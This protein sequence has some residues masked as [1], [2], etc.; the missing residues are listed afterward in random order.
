[1]SD[2]QNNKHHALVP[3]L[4]GSLEKGESGAKRVLSAIISDTIAL[5]KREQRIRPRIVVVDDEDWML[6]LIEACI[7]SWSEHVTLL[8]FQNRNDAWQ[9]LLR[10]DPNLLI[11]DMN[12][13]NVPGRTQSFGMSGWHML[14]LLAERKVK[15]P[16]LVVSGSFSMS[17]VE[18][19]ARQC[20]G[21]DLNVSYLPK[22][23]TME[24]FNL[25]LSKLLGSVDNPFPQ[26]RKD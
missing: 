10:A 15:Y 26:P 18:S 1:M 6:N 5:A 4:P 25:E 17:G 19:K 14:P 20:A 13:D 12:N 8:M 7:H 21:P 2:G 11:T 9:E 16:I 23:F 3:R 22:P 24:R